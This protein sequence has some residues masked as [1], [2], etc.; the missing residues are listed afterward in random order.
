MRGKK[1]SVRLI[2]LITAFTITLLAAG[3][4]AVAQEEMVLH[5][6]HNNGKDGQG[7]NSPL[8]FDSAG[9]LYGTT[10]DGGA[11]NAGT[12]FEMSPEAGGAW[13][14]K[15]L[16]SFDST[17]GYV[18]PIPSGALALD[19]SGNLYGVTGQG[20]TGSCFDLSGNGCGTVFALSPMAGGFWAYSVLHYFNNN[21][22]NDPGGGLIF[23]AHGNLYGAA[24]FGGDTN[25]GGTAFELSP[26]GGGKW[27]ESVLHDFPEGTIPQ[28][29]LIFDADGNLYGTSYDGGTSHLGTAFELSPTGDG[30]WTQTV[31]HS[32]VQNGTDGF[33]PNGGLVFDANGNLYGTTVSGGGTTANCPFVVSCGTVFELS[34][35]GGG[36]WTETIIHPF[37]H[38]GADGSD[39]NDGLAIDSSGNLYGTTSLGGAYGGGTVFELTPSSGSWAET[40]LHSFGHVGDGKSPKAPLVFDTSGNLYGTTSEGG[41]DG[42]G[43]VFEITP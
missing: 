2:R 7:P 11:H 5:S 27:T 29:P 35:A 19:T 3:A 16:Y 4:S 30:G 33:S 31:L 13:T 12:V 6:F 39:P 43:T 26:A 34:P 40:L 20:G 22:G 21:G 8:V 36:I 10:P 28:G 9:N 24:A 37:S 41:L 25:A 32:F 42:L 18:G 1:L 15:P 17:N 14:E 38:T 23:D